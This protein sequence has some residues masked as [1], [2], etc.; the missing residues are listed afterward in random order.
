MASRVRTVIYFFTHDWHNH[1]GATNNFGLKLI[2]QKFW[3]ASYCP[4]Q[5]GI[6]DLASGIGSR[7]KFPYKLSFHA[8]VSVD[9]PCMDYAQCLANLMKLGP[10]T[11]LF[12]VSAIPSPG[13]QADVIGHI[14]LT[15]QLTTSKF[16][17]E[18]LFF[19][20]QLMEEDFALEPA[21]LAAI[22]KKKECAMDCTSTFAPKINKGCISPFTET[23]HGMLSSDVDLLV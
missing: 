14:Y 7:G 11:K 22:D 12:E 4:I 23:E 17:D 16:G 1:I 20:H 3:Q 6:S 5:V 10:G 21:W 9:C 18:A 13:G 8:L 2:A 15:T 19:K